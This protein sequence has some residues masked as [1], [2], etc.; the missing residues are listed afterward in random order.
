MIT[1]VKWESSEKKSVVRTEG[2]LK[3]FAIIKFSHDVRYK[4]DP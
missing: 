2:V 4:F 1:P 3:I